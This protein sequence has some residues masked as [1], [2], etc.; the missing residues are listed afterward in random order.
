M[1]LGQVLELMS[2]GPANMHVRLP[3]VDECVATVLK[4]VA[5]VAGVD[6]DTAMAGQTLKDIQQCVQRLGVWVVRVGQLQAA[7]LGVLGR[8]GDNGLILG[9]NSRRSVER[10]PPGAAA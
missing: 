10:S 8:L 5:V 1:P 6:R 2:D 4:T 7:Q 3:Y 9:G